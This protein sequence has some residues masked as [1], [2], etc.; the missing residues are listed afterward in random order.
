MLISANN[1][2][3]GSRTHTSI[4]SPPPQ[5]GA[6]AIPPLPRNYFIK[7]SLNALKVN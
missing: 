2:V 6:S 5:D 4:H 1:A 3:D 7:I